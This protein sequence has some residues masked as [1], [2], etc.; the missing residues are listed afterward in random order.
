MEQSFRFYYTIFF[1]SRSI[2]TVWKCTED[3]DALYAKWATV[4][5]S[6]LDVD[7][8]EEG[9]AMIELELEEAKGAVFALIIFSLLPVRETDTKKLRNFQN[10]ENLQFL[11]HNR[12]WNIPFAKCQIT[13][14]KLLGFLVPASLSDE[15]FF[16]ENERKY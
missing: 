7:D 16:W 8:C 14:L 1:K 11:N 13:I 10:F 4:E 3:W 5:F 12:D 6:Q 15:I 9:T 2:T